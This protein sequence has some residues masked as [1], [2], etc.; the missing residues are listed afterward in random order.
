MKRETRK[1]TLRCAIYTRVSTENGLEQ[2]FN[3]LDNQREASEA[4][5]RSQAHE[6]WKLIRDRYD[7]GGFS[8]GSM[9]RPALARLLDDVR[10]RR[11]DVIVVYKVD[12]LT[13]S[14]ADFAK[15]VELFDEHDVSFI[16]VTQA[17]NTTTSMGRL[18]LNMLLSFA[19]FEREITGER[20]RDKVAASKKRGIWMG[21]AVPFGYRVESRALHIVEEHAEFVSA[22]FRR[23]L[24]VGSVVRLK[25]ALDAENVRLPVREVGTGRTTGGGLISRG[26]LYWIL[27]NPIYV[28]Q[29]RHKGQIHNGLHVAIVDQETWDRVQ[30]RL[31][32]QTQPR[33]NPRPNSESFLVGKLYDDRGNRMGP[34]HAAKGGQ[35][36]RYYISRAILTGR[37][38]DAGSVVRVPAAQ[39][40]KQVF[41]AVK[42][43]LA[44][45]RLIDK[46]GERSRVN[47]T[48]DA[49]GAYPTAGAPIQEFSIHQKVLDAI[50]RVTIGATQV[51]I[52]LI[53]VDGQDRVLTL[54]WTRASSHR[55]REIIQGVGEAQGPLRAMRTKARDSFIG[56]LRDARRWLDEL[57][58]DPAQTIESLAMREHKSERS[59]RMTVSLAF[60]SPVLAK[61]A[62]EGRLPRGFSVKRLT[63]LPMLWSDQ[64]RAVGL[65]EPIQAELG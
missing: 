5:V 21:G 2:E 46:S 27:S 13:R 3:S 42:H 57:L 31:E 18:T 14:L 52:Q 48:A 40:E 10:A 62:M 55:R 22:L 19:Q 8:G 49:A 16:S 50:E 34:S 54:P 47:P 23:Y 17:F 20:I 38:S 35:R 4:Y 51:E 59:I 9:D 11:V 60:V 15:L 39:I 36:W 33:A 64:W 12:R 26:H 1:A 44:S 63:D 41:N 56:A 53:V 65:R 6:G 32:Q 61:A 25:A 29:L 37:K 28:G 24:E 58:I 43:A 30:R 45:N 7:D